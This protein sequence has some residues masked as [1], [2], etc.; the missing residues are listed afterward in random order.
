MHFLLIQGFVL[1]I[2]FNTISGAELIVETL[3]VIYLKIQFWDTE[4]TY[5]DN[6]TCFVL[7]PH[8]LSYLFQKGFDYKN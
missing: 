3:I 1:K 2:H 8:K 5:L 4:E 7:Y 6:K